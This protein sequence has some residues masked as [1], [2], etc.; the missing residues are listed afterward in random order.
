MF[1]KRLKELRKLNDLSMRQL[2][3]MIGVPPTNISNWENVGSEPDYSTLIK[4]ANIFDVSTDYLVGRSHEFDTLEDKKKKEISILAQ[5]L[6]DEFNE[7]PSV[8]RKK[9]S[10]DLIKYIQFLGYII[11]RHE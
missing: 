3:E 4:L 6:Y 11:K 9:V 7:I 10:E 5:E 1:G 2:G 8:R